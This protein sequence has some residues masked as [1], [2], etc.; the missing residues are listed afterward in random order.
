[1]ND[2]GNGYKYYIYLYHVKIRVAKFSG[3]LSVVNFPREFWEYWEF[4]GNFREFW[5]FLNSLITQNEN[6]KSTVKT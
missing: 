5:E 3:I 4:C 6:D 2:T 1:M